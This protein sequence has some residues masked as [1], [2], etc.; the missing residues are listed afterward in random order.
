MPFA[1][2]ISEIT[3]SHAPGVC[4]THHSGQGRAVG[5]EQGDSKRRYPRGVVGGKTKG[6]INGIGEV[7]VLNLSLGGALIEHAEVI[8]PDTILE[9]VL[10]LAGRETRLR[11]R[12]V[13]S[14]IHRAE[15]QPDGEQELIF[16]TGL[17]FLGSS[18]P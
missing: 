7:S 17:D 2:R 16:R 12:V 18:C 13:W 1:L 15:V 14:A 8:R 10:T 4:G 6:R 11:F 5:K 3:T 9:L